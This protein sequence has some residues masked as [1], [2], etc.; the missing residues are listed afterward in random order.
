M[1]K[2][3]GL[4]FVALALCI[5]GCASP[6]AKVDLKKEQSAA[7]QAYYVPADEFKT[8]RFDPPPVPGSDAQK[9]DLAVVMDWQKKRTGADCAGAEH[10]SFVS[11][12]LF[13]GDKVF[14][15][16]KEPFRASGA[17]EVK[18]FFKRLD[19]DAGE[20]VEV[21]KDRFR[22]PRPFAAYT[23][24]RPC[25]KKS[26]SHSYPSGHAAYAWLFAAVLG[27]MI[28]ERRDEFMKKAGDV[29]LDRVIGGVH[30]PADIEAGKV[31]ADEFHARLLKNPAYLRDIE[32]I[33]C[34]RTTFYK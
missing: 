6:A 18:E 14:W 20:A 9:A 24:V 11:Y 1:K 32:K 30:Y 15:G 33:K 4:F 10:V 29:A 12:D 31:F 19:A 17:D 27:D 13:W 28:P 2:Q 26:R 25:V 5:G 23:E 7:A 21:M 34:C 8:M 22:R 3:L 16:D